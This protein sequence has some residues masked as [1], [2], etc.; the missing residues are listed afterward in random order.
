MYVD[1]YKLCCPHILPDDFNINHC[2]GPKDILSSCGSLIAS[3]LYRTTFAVLT[4][5]G[6]LSH[7]VSITAWVFLV[8]KELKF[9]S[10][11]FFV[12]LTGCDLLMGVHTA[13]VTIADHVFRGYYVWKDIVWRRSIM[14]QVSS[15]VFFL[16]TDM[17]AFL[18]CL[19]TLDR[20]FALRFSHKHA[21]VSSR[22]THACCSIIWAGCVLLAVVSLIPRTP[23]EKLYSRS[24]ACQPLTALLIDPRNH[25]Y[26]GA[27][28][29]VVSLVLL[30]ITSVAQLYVVT[31]VRREDNIFTS[32]Q[33][34]RL[35]SK[36]YTLS[37]RVFC[38]ILFHVLCWLWVFLCMLLQSAGILESSDVLVGTSLLVMPLKSTLNPC[39]YLVGHVREHQRHIQRKRLIQRL[40]IRKQQ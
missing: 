28:L 2:H 23:E 30:V 17:S 37:R 19:M 6:I 9:S 15:F 4:V 14:C 40:G 31:V 36:E 29:V 24:G 16:S 21:R 1:D 39:M 3:T 35:V 26:I 12:H 5:L 25:E 18:T 7:L 33:T 20:C 8:K 38:V 27:A 10:H 22:A 34:G 11:M 32:L 13:T